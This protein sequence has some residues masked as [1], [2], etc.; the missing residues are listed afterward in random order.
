MNIF[1][2]A[3]LLVTLSLS[4]LA[5]ATGAGSNEDSLTQEAIVARLPRVYVGPQ[6]SCPQG[7][8]R[9]NGLCYQPCRIAGADPATIRA[10][11]S[12][13]MGCPVGSVF[14][15]SNTYC[16][17]ASNSRYPG[18]SSPPYAY[19]RGAGRP[20]TC[21]RGLESINGSCYRP[22]PSGF[23]SQGLLGCFFD[24]TGTARQ[25]AEESV[26]DETPDSS[27]NQGT[28]AQGSGGAQQSNSN[29]GSP[30]YNCLTRGMTWNG[31]EC[32]RNG[33][34][35]FD[36]GEGDPT[37]SLQ[38]DFNDVNCSRLGGCG[39]STASVGLGSSSQLGG[40]T[41]D[42]IPTDNCPYPSAPSC[43]RH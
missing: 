23:V 21:R 43:F 16:Q 31:F 11:E 37:P 38:S 2:R 7:L 3:S 15:Q 14:V 12:R 30:G 41:T 8:E 20:V 40:S 26:T 28:N 13:C 27:S 29:I 17:F 1:A 6:D 32:V 5:C 34:S 25:M 36:T 10:V 22:C 42:F 35:S 33:P 19:D 9:L 39:G 24:P 4:M 18:T